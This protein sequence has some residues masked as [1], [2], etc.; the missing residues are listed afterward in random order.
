MSV[1]RLQ[2]WSCPCVWSCAMGYASCS[3]RDCCVSNVLVSG[4]YLPRS[5][6][7]CDSRLSSVVAQAAVSTERR[8]LKSWVHIL[9]NEMGV[10]AAIAAARSERSG[11]EYEQ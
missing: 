1:M 8:T 11:L 6:S 2:L 4:I 3:L 10:S 5:T 9:R 7:G